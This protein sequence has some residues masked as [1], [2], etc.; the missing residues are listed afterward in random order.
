MKKDLINKIIG[1]SL[2]LFIEAWKRRSVKQSGELKVY[3]EGYWDGVIDALQIGLQKGRASGQL[4]TRSAELD[5]NLIFERGNYCPSC[6]EEDGLDA[7]VPW[8][9]A[10]GYSPIGSDDSTLH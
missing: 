9:A 8:C 5:P 3:R 10:C 4:K 7:G 1:I 6:G 2:P